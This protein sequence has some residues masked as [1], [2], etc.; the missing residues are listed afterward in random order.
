MNYTSIEQSKRLIELGLYHSSADMYYGYKKEKPEYLP[1]KDIEVVALCIPC[2]S[3]GKLLELIKC[4]TRCEMTLRV[5][6]RWNIFATKDDKVFRS[7]DTK[8]NGYETLFSAVYEVVVWL[9]ENKLV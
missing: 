4:C 6:K 1:Y 2:W 8:T 9:L 3:I 7:Y 5:D